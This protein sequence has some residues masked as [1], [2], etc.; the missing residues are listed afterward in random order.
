MAGH[1]YL[2]GPDRSRMRKKVFEASKGKCAMCGH[3]CDEHQGDMDHIKGNTKH[4][5]CDC[6]RR[7]LKDGTIHTNVQWLHGMEMQ[8][9]CHQKKDHRNLVFKHPWREQWVPK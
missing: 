3:A 7:R 2:R 9:S 8:D 1:I 6:F 5:R 4:T